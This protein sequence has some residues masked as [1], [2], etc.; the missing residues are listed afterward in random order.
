MREFFRGWK[1]KTSVATL[2]MACGLTVGW[3][4]SYDTVDS[5]NIVDS[6]ITV[7]GPLIEFW[8]RRMEEG[9]SLSGPNTVLPPIPYWSLV[10]PLALASAWLLL[11]DP[12]PS[13]RHTDG[14]QTPSTTSE[15]R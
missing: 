5:I 14:R 2:L 9:V 4:R 11:S 1:R 3:I 7:L 15:T 13:K 8:R 6:Q 12:R 10:I